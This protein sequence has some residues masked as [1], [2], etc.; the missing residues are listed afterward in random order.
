M[1][2]EQ[3]FKLSGGNN[4]GPTTTGSGYRVFN[5]DRDIV[6]AFAEAAVPD[7]FAGHGHP[8]ALPDRPEPRRRGTTTSRTWVIPPIRSTASTGASQRAAR[9][10]QL[11]QVV[12]GTADRGHGRRVAG[13]SLCVGQRGEHGHDQRSGRGSIRRRGHPGRG[14][15]QHQHSDCTA[16]ST[17][18]HHRPEQHGH[19]PPARWRASRGWVRSSVRVIRSAST[20]RRN[21]WPGFRGS[22]HVL[23]QRLH[24]R[25]QFAIAGVD[26]GF[27]IAAA[28]ALPDGMHAGADPRVRERRQRCDHRRIDSDQRCTT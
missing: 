4:T 19:A 6:S 1:W 14:R 8:R 22:A 21:A 26:H 9:P 18:L 15:G 2:Q 13:L 20:S 24:G 7:R 27:R 10:R 23:P 3:Q 11:R 17:C 16:T 12:R 5:Y 25:R 28:D